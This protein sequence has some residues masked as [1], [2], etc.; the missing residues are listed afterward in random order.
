MTREPEIKT[1]KENLGTEALPSAYAFEE[2]E[3]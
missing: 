3:S 1:Q 2:S